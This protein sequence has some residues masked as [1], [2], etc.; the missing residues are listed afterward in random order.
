MEDKIISVIIPVYN[1]EK[2]LNRCIDSVVNQTYTNLEIILIDDG[3]SDSSGK[4]ADEWGKRD[5]RIKVIH[6]K[7][8]GVSVA[9]NY[10]VELARG[11]YI[12]FVD[13]DDYIEKNM[14]E[15]LY[16]NILYTN[17]NIS[18][19]NYY[20]VNQD[21]TYNHKH[22]ING[23]LLIIENQQDFFKLL[24]RNYY[25]GFV[26]NK[27]FEREIVRNIK[28]D[29]KIHMCEDLLWV[30]RIA[31][32]SIK[33]CFDN[34]CLYY[35]VKREDSA[36]NS[37]MTEKNISVIKAYESIIK[38]L[39]ENKIKC[40]DEYKV[41]LFYWQRDIEKN[42]KNKNLVRKLKIDNRKIYKQI[43]K[44]KEVGLKKKLDVFIRY[45]FYGIFRK[46]RQLKRKMSII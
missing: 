14:F 41:T 28:F 42:I 25:R 15:I 45:R 23:N 20:I 9:R 29:E 11:K 33:Y 16:K 12:G 34:R 30:S 36:Y 46:I 1:V 22:N 44:S 21:Y 40:V 6:K 24:N 13:S 43:I 3:S 38:M 37:G 2:Y 10:G 17:S 32:E 27:I 35:Y 5:K 7:N 26:W 39:E 31:T 18:M 19:C 4:I 8:E